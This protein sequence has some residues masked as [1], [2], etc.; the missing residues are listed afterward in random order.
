MIDSNTLE[1]MWTLRRTMNPSSSADFLEALIE[2]LK[3]TDNNA[4][5]LQNLHNL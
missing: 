1:L 4:T 2:R 3:K 5:F